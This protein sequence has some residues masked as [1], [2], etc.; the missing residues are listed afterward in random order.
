M[1]DQDAV[2]RTEGLT[3]D[4]GTLRA[5]DG[6]TIEVRRGSVFGFLGPNGSGKTT[7]I[8][9]L[10][11]LIATTS[12]RANVMGFDAAR[13][14]SDIRARSGCLLEHSGIYDRLSAEDNLDLFGRI[15]KLS[16]AERRARIK[17]VLQSFSLWDRRSDAAGSWSRGMKQKLAIARVLLHRPALVFLDEPTAGLDP[18]AAAALRDDLAALARREGVTVFLT[19]HNLSEAEKLCARVAVIRRG[20]LLAEGAPEELRVR[21][22][23]QRVEIEGRG[24]DDHVLAALRERPEIGSA[25]VRDGR[26][27]V[28]LKNNSPM[29]PL[30]P[31]LVSA[32]VEIEEIRKER[33]SLEDVFMTLMEEEG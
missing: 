22:S 19:T 31:L 5:V 23:G 17:E 21:K 26:L 4:F 30:V 12:G 13:Q 2:I 33:A 32:G 18:L 9:M 20:R 8:R 10:L 24:F 29:A 3:R 11:G 28:D 27:V 25:E 14:A 1:H 15:W 7:T 16:A 6:L